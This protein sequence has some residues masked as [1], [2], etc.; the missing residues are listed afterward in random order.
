MSETRL[1]NNQCY[2]MNGMHVEILCLKAFYWEPLFCRQKEFKNHVGLIMI[3]HCDQMS[4]N[5]TVDG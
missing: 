1:R 4:N 3:A 2:I 5:K